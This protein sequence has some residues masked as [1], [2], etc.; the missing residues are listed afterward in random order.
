MGNDFYLNPADIHAGIMALN[1]I[2]ERN[3]EQLRRLKEQMEACIQDESFTS[4][5]ASESKLRLEIITFMIDAFRAQS[6]ELVQKMAQL[7]AS[8]GEETLEGDKLYAALEQARAYYSLC[9][10]IAW[11]YE[12][13]SVW[14]EDPFSAYWY[15]NK[16]CG[17]RRIADEQQE[18][19]R[20]IQE[21]ID[22]YYQIERTTLQ[23][24]ESELSAV[25]GLCG[26]IQNFCRFVD[27]GETMLRYKPD[28]SVSLQEAFL[29]TIDPRDMTQ[30]QLWF[31][32]QFL[33][34]ALSAAPTISDTQE[35]RFF[36][37][38]GWELVISGQMTF[39]TPSAAQA[40]QNLISVDPQVGSK[41]TEKGASLSHQ[42]IMVMGALDVKSVMELD[43]KGKASQEIKISDVFNLKMKES[44]AGGVEA[45][46]YGFVPVTEGI[47]VIAGIKGSE[48]NPLLGGASA[49]PVAGIKY[50]DESTGDIYQV[51]LSADRRYTTLS[52]ERE[53]LIMEGAKWKIQVSLI[54][55]RP[56]K[57]RKGNQQK[58]E[59]TPD[60]ANP[61]CAIRADED[62]SRALTT[63][64]IRRR[65]FGLDIWERFEEEGFTVQ[66][67]WDIW[68]I[69]LASG[70]AVPGFG[71]FP[72]LVP[73]F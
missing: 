48:E 60:A 1:G 33:S 46:A 26:D 51:K 14:A 61:E 66:A 2:C 69:L 17:W 5:S 39:E 28:F 50:T 10:D 58:K 44:I 20:R 12:Q 71:S 18:L 73:A 24:F 52:V 35:Q 62:Y 11:T 45:E 57:D 6:Q 59:D 65:A 30:R 43:V 23:F 55:L 27:T 49:A 15:A 47:N 3:E 41:F 64:E 16:A 34:G 68:E 13:Q 9:L 56:G 22:A 67:L 7:D 19:M 70:F 8:V 38:P 32:E 37:A 40:F 31:L 53:M 63:E 29:E 72:A 25:K 4:D 54:R 21:K 42:V 36:L